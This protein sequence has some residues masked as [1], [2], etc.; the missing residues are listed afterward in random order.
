[1]AN[2]L[3]KVNETSR[4]FSE[5]DAQALHTI[6]VKFL[7]LCKRARPDILTGVA[8][9]TTRVR[10]LEKYNSKKLLRILKYLSGTRDLVLALESD[11]TRTLKWLVDTE[12]AVHHDIKSHTGGMMTMGRG[13]LYSASNKQK[14]NTKSSNEVKL[15]G[16]DD[17]MPQM[18]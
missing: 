6:V 13:T 8:L 18:L 11:G 5:K 3:F 12:F 7:F 10:D 14:L 4:K 17:P 15:V 9:P 16:V 2:H 1:M